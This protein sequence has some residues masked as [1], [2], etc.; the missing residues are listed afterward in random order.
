LDAAVDMVDEYHLPVP[1]EPD[2]LR[3]TCGSGAGASDERGSTE[4]TAAAHRDAVRRAPRGRV[5]RTSVVMP[6][7]FVNRP[8]LRGVHR[9]SGCGKPPTSS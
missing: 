3:A 4:V 6:A 8:D 9:G 1:C 2:V 5:L 7:F